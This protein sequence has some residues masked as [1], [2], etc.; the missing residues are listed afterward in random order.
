MNVS[1]TIY[2]ESN[3]KA[4][5]SQFVTMKNIFNS[6]ND[7]ETKKEDINIKRNESGLLFLDLLYDKLTKENMKY[8]KLKLLQEYIDDNEYDSDGIVYDTFDTDINKSVI[9]IYLKSKDL[10]KFFEIISEK[11]A[12]YNIILEKDK[13]KDK[14]KKK[15]QQKQNTFYSFGS[16]YY[17][18]KWYKNN[19]DY[20][21]VYNPGYRYKDWYI[22]KKFDNLKQEILNKLDISQFE[23]T[24]NK[25]TMILN[26]SMHY[27]YMMSRIN[28]D[29]YGGILHYDIAKD[30][31]ITIENLMSVIFYTDYSQLSF[32]FSA[33]FRKRSKNETNQEMKQ[34]NSFFWNWSK[35]LMETVHLYGYRYNYF[36]W[37]N[38]EPQI[39]TLYHGISTMYFSSFIT[40]F[41]G[42][43][44]MTRQI[45]VASI[46]AQKGIILE[47]Q[48]HGGYFAHHPFYFNCTFLSCFGNEDER[49]FIGG[50][51]YC[52]SWSI[53]TIPDGGCLQ[54][55]SIR[56]MDTDENYIWFV[57]ALSILDTIIKGQEI[58]NFRKQFRKSQKF[59]FKIIHCLI[60]SYHAQNNTNDNIKNKNDKLTMKIPKYIQSCFAEMVKQIKKVKF[61]L[62]YLDRLYPS[63]QKI[64]KFSNNE[65]CK[66]NLL[67]FD[68]ICNLFPQCSN[69]DVNLEGKIYD[70]ITN[71]FINELIK[72]L[73]KICDNKFFY[74]LK[75][76]RLIKFEYS[77][78]IDTDKIRLLFD[79]ENEK[80]INWDWKIKETVKD[81][82]AVLHIYNGTFQDET[83]RNEN[84]I[85][86]DDDV[87]N[88]NDQLITKQDVFSISESDKKRLESIKKAK[89]KNKNKNNDDDNKE[90]LKSDKD[91]DDDDDEVNENKV[92][93][94]KTMFIN[95]NS[96]Q[97]LLANNDFRLQ[98]GHPL[99]T[100]K[101]N[102]YGLAEFALIPYDKEKNL[103][104]IYHVKKKRFIICDDDH[105]P[106]EFYSNFKEINGVAIICGHKY[107]NNNDIDEYAIW[108]QIENFDYDDKCF[109]FKNIKS[110]RY[111]ASTQERA[112]NGYMGYKVIG[113]N[114]DNITSSSAQCVWSLYQWIDDQSRDK[115]M[116]GRE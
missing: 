42:P 68:N 71:L 114:K 109:M 4:L 1:N 72:Q 88:N 26:N 7:D 60:Q 108:E 92:I 41:C 51:G 67:L 110:N 66:K 73:K 29:S 90:S 77:D 105:S 22:N 102:Y 87:N 28:T 30:V 65:K 38:P 113:I 69:I 86:M 46:F 100:A 31:P 21:I 45:S 53:D 24:K 97:A 103:V 91:D 18:W 9:G 3:N 63:F 58:S 48:Q 64:I 98:G 20:D 106:H 35:L 15:N 116:D 96:G 27:K 8:D 78:D 17:Y 85:E 55:R 89:E 80:N 57:R 13:Q 5:K 36:N 32:S 62:Y 76:I 6:D 54:L 112:P 39:K 44:S 23:A 16:R 93:K 115:L 14:D 99:Q 12:G 107:M 79:K 59:Y 37:Q 83:K 82:V 84:D 52:G 95:V 11:A 75:Q 40:R 74:K 101:A 49:L 25:A 43:T 50:A 2:S 111:I 34:R 33:T 19:I 56:I 10:N 47:I 81:K 94:N 104:N 70:K 61:D